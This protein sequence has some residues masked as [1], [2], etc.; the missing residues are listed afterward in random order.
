MTLTHLPLYALSRSL[1]CAPGPF[2]V[3]VRY[4]EPVAYLFAAMLNTKERVPVPVYIASITYAYTHIRA[5][6]PLF[7]YPESIQCLTVPLY[8]Y[9]C[10]IIYSH[11]LKIFVSK[12]TWLHSTQYVPYNLA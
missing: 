12:T 6:E 9:L 4:L 7:E 5:S 2:L 1:T 11:N 10:F 8:T 3:R